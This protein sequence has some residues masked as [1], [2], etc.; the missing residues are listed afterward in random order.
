MDSSH[1]RQL[2]DGL[3]EL[4]AG[5]FP[6][7][8]ANCG[9]VFEDLPQFLAETVPIARDRSGLKASVDDDEQPLVEL[10]RNCPCGSTLMDF[11]RSR[12]DETADG[13][14]RRAVFA[15]MLEL[16]VGRGMA[17]ETARAELLKV[18]HGGSGERLQRLLK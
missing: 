18:V 15:R 6:K 10:F 12:R 2:F 11:C 9:R 5:A 8:C 3:Q 16:L 17:S 13:Q 14:R 1:E 7:V 4:S